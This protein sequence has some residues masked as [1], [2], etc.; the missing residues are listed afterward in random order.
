MIDICKISCDPK[1]AEQNKAR[2]EATPVKNSPTKMSRD[3]HYGWVDL[4]EGL[5]QTGLCRGDIVFFQISHITLGTPEFGDSGLGANEL[6]YSAMREVIGPEGTLL[7]PAYSFAFDRNADFDIKITPSIEGTWSSSLEFLEYFRHLPGVVRS[8]D[9]IFSAAGLGPQAQRLLTQLPNTS[10]GK[11]CL[12]ERLL[13]AGAKISGIG[14]GL[15]EASFI[16]Y[17]E[18]SL[19]VPFRY[20]K[21]FTGRVGQNGKLAKQGWISSVPIQ[22]ADGR[23]NGSRVEQMARSEGRSRIAQVGLG[24]LVTIDCR[25]FYEL[26]AREITRDPWTTAQ[27]PG[28]CPVELEKARASSHD[29]V[30]ELPENASMEDLISTLW[31]LPRDIVSDGYD[32]ALRALSTQ[33]PMVV[34]EYPTGTE[35][36]TWLVPEKWTCQE[37]GLETLDGRRLL[38]YADNPLHVVSYSLPIDREVSREELFEH[39]HVHPELPDAIPF[40]FKYYE[41]DWGLCCSQRLKDSLRDD[42]YRVVIKSDFSYG[43]LKV[44]EVIAPGRTAETFI[45]CA[46]LCHPA[47]VNDD[48]SGVVVGLKVMQELQKRTDLHYTYRLLILP[49][50]I[51]SVAYLS[52]HQELIP[53]MIGGIFLEMLGLQNPHA[54]QLSFSGDTEADRCL[55]RALKECDPDGWTSPFRTVV[56]N[57]ERQ[58]NAPGVRVP[59]LSLSRV[60][61]RRAG[62]WPYYPEYHSSH[63]TPELASVARLADSRDLVL[64]MIDTVEGNRVPVNRFQGEIFCS[65]YGIN[66]DAYTSPESNQALFDII[67]LIDGTRSVAEIAR[68]CNVSIESASRVVAELRQ[69]RLVE[70]AGN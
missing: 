66:I 24:E 13:K 20:K 32:T 19:G 17:V 14:V 15:A 35:C 36:W 67:F 64:K 40:I 58:F 3:A 43:T 16:H 54:L 41:R 25:S 48:L 56:G 68:I 63:D 29:A 45:L 28:G 57:D 53:K 7:L 12:H 4:V 30:I 37:A 55:S 52:H 50:T 10:Y 62:I 59:M 65:R 18:E 2:S 21:L 44:G 27:G 33:V 51:G 39:L 22:A 5:K 42:R 26:L 60:G 31:R 34:H 9:P 49:E 47:M 1:P 61:Q 46:H 38:S 8:A 23:P 69:L 11:D 70:Y 6:L